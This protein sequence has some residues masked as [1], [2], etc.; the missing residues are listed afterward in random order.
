MENVIRRIKRS[1][2][3]FG[4]KKSKAPVEGWARALLVALPSG[5]ISQ[6]I[7]SNKDPDGGRE[8]NGLELLSRPAFRDQHQAIRT[9][10]KG[11]N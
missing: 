3:E 11:R 8:L 4:L 5:T 7:P 9:Q 2:A 10:T 6:P 1:K